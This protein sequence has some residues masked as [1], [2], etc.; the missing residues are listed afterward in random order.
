MR[1]SPPDVN[2][3]GFFMYKYSFLFVTLSVFNDDIHIS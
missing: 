3:A 2:P 1:E